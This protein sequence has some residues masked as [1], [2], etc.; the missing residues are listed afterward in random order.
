MLTF[1]NQK[2]SNPVE[3]NIE[4]IIY[5]FPALLRFTAFVMH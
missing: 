2:F 4:V 5:I 1:Q 3:K